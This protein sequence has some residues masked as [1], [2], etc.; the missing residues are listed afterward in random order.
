MERLTA[1][2]FALAWPD[3][4][5]RICTQATQPPRRPTQ[6]KYSAGRMWIGAS[7]PASPVLRWCGR[8]VGRL[9]PGLTF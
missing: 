4:N 7:G 1:L 2:T 5:R 3:H 9:G 6:A 8:R